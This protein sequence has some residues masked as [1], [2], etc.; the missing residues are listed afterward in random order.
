[1]T[2]RLFA[3]VGLT[4]LAA[5]SVVYY[6]GFYG[7]VAILCAAVLIVP[8][9]LLVKRARIYR[10]VFLC[11]A[12][13][14]VLS[15]IYFNIFSASFFNSYEKYDKVRADVTATITEIPVEKF[16]Q[17]YFEINVDKIDGEDCDLSALL[18]SEK[19]PNLS[20]GDRIRCR[21]RLKQM[22]Y[23]FYLSDGIG[24]IAK[25]EDDPFKPQKL[26]REE[27]IK[28]FP[29]FLREKISSAI[30][31]LLPKPQSDLCEAVILGNK[32]ALSEDMY[33]A[34]R[35]SGFS[36]VIVV[37]GMHLSIISGFII[38]ILK[39]LGGRRSARIIRLVV[40][41]FFVMLYMAVTGFSPAV[42]R[43]GIMVMISL[44]GFVCF[45][46]AD[47][48]NSLGIA[49]IIITVANPLSVGNI[50]LLMSFASVIG[51]LYFFPKLMYWYNPLFAPRIHKL[52]DVKKRCVNL[53]K[54][55]SAEYIKTVIALRAFHR[56]RAVFECFA[57]SVSALLGV[58]PIMVY[59]FGSISPLTV[60]ASIF[61]APVIFVLMIFCLFAILFYYLSFGMI[62]SILA[63]FARIFASWTII[64][65]KVTAS[66]P[67]SKIYINPV[68]FSILLILFL[69][70]FSVAM[71]FRRRRVAV[72]AVV[73]ISAC[74]VSVSLIAGAVVRHN[75]HTLSFLNSGDGVV[76]LYESGD[77]ACLL[78]CGGDYERQSDVIKELHYT[79]GELDLI[80]IPSGDSGYTYYGER[81]TEEFEAEE[82]IV[83]RH[84][85]SKV[86][87]GELTGRAGC[88]VINDNARVELDLGDGVTDTIFVSDGVTWQYIKGGNQSVLIA[89]GNA[90]I[91]ALPSEYRKADVLVLSKLIDGYEQIDCKRIIWS[92]SEKIPDFDKETSTTADGEVVVD[93]E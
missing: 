26:G 60:I 37:S 25:P 52:Y 24:L 14:A 4:M 57:V 88:R 10:S 64:V 75:S 42:V 45:R 77:R 51:I 92:S 29:L 12:V 47:K 82:Y 30:R 54:R 38:S 87:F 79:A 8:F 46:R 70:L 81:I 89:P 16:G 85:V 83:Q 50:G 61:I 91:D 11:V 73:A 32:Q 80:F 78:S 35:K 93:L 71:L 84:S 2:R 67:F 63:F 62:A 76:A 19:N 43:S 13:A 17:V 15:V 74:F 21:V 55:K 56:M 41:S 53:Q 49:A 31:E 69:S 58:C 22:K 6:F 59:F 40:V 1:M 23:G 36:Y 9:A 27:G 28:Y 18:I 65:V 48:F 5:F 34:F 20:Y 33:Y 72:S 68:M 66:M 39:R 86:D 7:A 3:Y 90:E 44:F